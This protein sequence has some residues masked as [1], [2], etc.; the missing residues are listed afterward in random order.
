MLSIEP[1]DILGVHGRPIRVVG[2]SVQV[3]F[4]GGVLIVCI[5]AQ[6]SDGDFAQPTISGSSSG[7][8]GAI[9]TRLK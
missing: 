3:H 7:V 2:A 4:E 6:H 5:F 9:A 8:Q 1:M